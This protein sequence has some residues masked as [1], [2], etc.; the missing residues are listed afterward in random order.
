MIRKNAIWI[1][2]VIAAAL[3]QTTWIDHIRLLGVVPDLTVILVVYFALMEGEERAMFTGV[4]CGVF[5]DAATNAVLGL[6]I[7][8]LVIVGYTT[9]KVSTRLITEHPAIKSALVFGGSIGNGLIITLLDY[10]QSPDPYALNTVI[11][12][13]VP[14][15]FYTAL[16]TPLVFWALDRLLGRLATAQ[17]GTT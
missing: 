8:S 6:H 4:L 3:I 12:R 17:G 16:I 1:V 11:A 9:G 10:L 2:L 5:Q 13:V 15:A 14:G 7:L